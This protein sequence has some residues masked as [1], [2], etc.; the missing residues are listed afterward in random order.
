MQKII[1]T[2]S[3]VALERESYPLTNKIKN[4]IYETRKKLW[5]IVIL[6]CFCVLC[7]QIKRRKRKVKETKVGKKLKNQKAI[8]LIA[9][10]ITIIVLLILAA[11]SIATLTGENG[12]LTNATKS[13]K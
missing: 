5:N 2:E 8:T 9:L 6:S 11:V 7:Q 12:I 13:Q 1:G 4:V 3:F 10:V